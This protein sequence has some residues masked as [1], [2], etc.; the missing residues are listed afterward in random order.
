VDENAI[1][2]R[3]QEF[4]PYGNPTQGDS[5]PY[6]FT[7]EWWEDEV[8]LLYLRAR[9]Y[10]PETGTFLSR[11]AVEGEPPYSY[12]RG[13]SVNLTDPSGLFPFGIEDLVHYICKQK[14]TK[15]EYAGCVLDF[16]FLKS[17]QEPPDVSMVV[18]VSGCWAGPVPY[19]FN[20]YV[21]GVSIS[22]FPVRAGI[23]IVYDSSEK[24]QR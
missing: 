17:T 22:F 15:E 19:K 11:D 5:D 23:E 7:G 18:G 8:G 9:W 13:N 2:V 16:Y 10:L 24:T 3:Y 1:V 21:E 4:D 12:V 14:N 20:G 6:G